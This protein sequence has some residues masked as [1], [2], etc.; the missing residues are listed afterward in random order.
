MGSCE[1]IRYFSD[2]FNLLLKKVKPKLNSEEAI[3]EHYLDSLEGLLQ[4][5]LKDRSPSTLEEAQDLAYQIDRNLEFEEYICQINLS[6]SDDLWDTGDA[7]VAEPEAP[8]IFE[9]EFTPPKRKWSFS[10]TD[11]QNTSFQETPIEVEPFQDKEEEV[12]T[13]SSQTFE[14]HGYS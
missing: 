11:A 10:H 6:C 14:H 9:V 3:L 7:L 1:G 4:F 8:R 2:R 13:S 12:K 5:T